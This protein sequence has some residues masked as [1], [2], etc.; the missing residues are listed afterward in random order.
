MVYVCMIDKSEKRKANIEQQTEQS[1]AEH[2]I[3]SVQGVWLVFSCL[4]WA[5][6]S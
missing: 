6:L 1:R 2:S 3:V 5:G 4:C